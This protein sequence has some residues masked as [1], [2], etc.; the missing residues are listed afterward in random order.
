MQ[1]MIW[2]KDCYMVNNMK[3]GCRLCPRMCLADRSNNERGVC[4]E[5]NKIRLSRA[6]LHFW[7]EP[8]ISGEFGS[9]TVF[10]SG[11]NLRCVY[12]QNREISTGESG[13]EVTQDRLTEIF[14]KLQ[15]KGAHNINLVTPTHYVPLIIESVSCAKY[16]GL[17]IPV[18]Y[19][20]SGY[21]TQ[22]TIKAL[23]NTV[24]IY[25]TDFK[26]ASCKLAEKYSGAKD[27]PSVAKAALC[28][29][30][31]QEP[32]LQF[33]ENG[34]LKRGVIVRHLMLPGNLEDSKNVITYLYETFGEKIYLSIMRQFTP[35]KIPK[36]FP[37]LNRTIT[38]FEYEELLQYALDLGVENAFIQEEE[39]ASESFIPPFDFEGV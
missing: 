13:K 1:R 39:A 30:V 19:N 31:E 4:G 10:F 34:I 24:D 8:C 35:Y 33:D 12:C 21:E 2:Q 11:C 18:I 6:A 37:E 3:D 29:M 7:E 27:Y 9:G 17:N 38:D 28:Q 15:E 14:L 36:E 5:T 25:L 32:T 26:Y 22:D 20:T 23:R 16:K